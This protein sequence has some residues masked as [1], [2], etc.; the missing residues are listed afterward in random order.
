[1][2]TTI[3]VES[4]VVES[5]RVA[6]VRGLFDLPAHKTSSLRWED[7]LPLDQRPWSVG[8]ITGPSGCGKSTVARRLWP[9]QA[10][11]SLDLPTDHSVL[12]ALPLTLSVKEVNALLSAAG[13]PSPP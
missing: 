12:D 4:P 8:L 9:G 11:R 5:P 3:T 10:A 2:K 6:Q 1:M 7:D 13:F